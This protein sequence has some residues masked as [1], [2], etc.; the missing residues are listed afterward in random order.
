MRCTVFL[1]KASGNLEPVLLEFAANTTVADVNQALVQ[2]SLG[3]ESGSGLKLAVPAGQNCSEE[4]PA[5]LLGHGL[6]V[7]DPGSGNSYCVSG[8]SLVADHPWL[9]G[10]EISLPDSNKV[11]PGVRLIGGALLTVSE[12]ESYLLPKG[13][14]TVGFGR[15]DIDVARTLMPA[16]VTAAADCDAVP[17]I[18]AEIKVG[19]AVKIR[20]SNS[21]PVSDLRADLDEADSAKLSLF[22]VAGVRVAVE[23]LADFD[24]QQLVSTEFQDS[25]DL[26]P[27]AAAASLPVLELPRIAEVAKP[28]GMPVYAWVAPLVLAG[29]LWL[30]LQTPTVLIF[31]A[32]SPIMLVGSLLESRRRFKRQHRAVRE[33]FAADW[34]LF[35]STLDRGVETL[36]RRDELDLPALSKFLEAEP[37][38]LWRKTTECGPVACS[39]GLVEKKHPQLPKL[40]KQSGI[41]PE[42][43]SLIDETLVGR[44]TVCRQQTLKLKNETKLAV[45]GAECAR[46]S[47]IAELVLQLA[48]AYAPSRVGFQF[49]GCESL[50]EKYWFSALPHTAKWREAQLL[51]CFIGDA[52][53]VPK[54]EELAALSGQSLVI[55]C[56]AEKAS[57]AFGNSV[58]LGETINTLVLEEEDYQTRQFLSRSITDNTVK[59][60]VRSLSRLAWSENADTE[61]NPGQQKA[62][63]ALEL[64]EL[65]DFST[66]GVVSAV[67][68]R[69][70]NKK[71][72]L[73]LSVLCAERGVSGFDLAKVGPHALIAGTTGSG[74]SELLQSLLLGMA[75]RNSPEIVQFLLADFK[76]GATFGELQDLPHTIALVTDLANDGGE[77]L[78]GGLKR[79]IVRRETLLQ[80][81]RASDIE[82]F[83]SRSAETLPIWVVA[84]DECAALLQQHPELQVSLQDLAQRGRSLG[85]H[86]VLATQK[87]GG[88]IN[89]RTRANI[90]LLFAMR[91]ASEGDS[92][93][94]LGGAEA[95]RLTE[96]DK[97]VGF[98]RAAGGSM[99][100]FINLS[101][102]H[103]VL[104]GVSLAAALVRVMSRLSDTEFQRPEK[105]TWVQE[106]PLCLTR[107]KLQEI[108][109]AASGIPE[110]AIGIIELPEERQR[111]IMTFWEGLSGNCAVVA[112]C[113]AARA[114]ALQALLAA[115]QLERRDELRGAIIRGQSS[116]MKVPASNSRIAFAEADDAHQILRLL[117]WIK[118]QNQLCVVVIEDLN[119]VLENAGAA[120]ELIIEALQSLLSDPTNLVLVGMRSTHS[121]PVRLRDK[122]RHIFLLQSSTV[123][124]AL[125]HLLPPKLRGSVAN[126]PAQRAIY[127]PDVKQ[128]QLREPEGCGSWRSTPTPLWPLLK[129]T[130][131][132][133]DAL[134]FEALGAALVA[135]AVTGFPRHGLVHFGGAP[136]LQENFVTALIAHHC[137]K[138][139]H[140]FEVSSVEMPPESARL[141]IV[142]ENL[143]SAGILTSDWVRQ[144]REARRLERTIML[145][146]TTAG[147]L[148]YGLLPAGEEPDFRVWIP[149][150]ET[151]APPEW[152]SARIA[153]QIALIPGG[154]VVQAGRN[155]GAAGADDLVKAVVLTAAVVGERV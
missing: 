93:E 74:K 115:S 152:V 47:Y 44:K 139:E 130:T 38:K 120:F 34:Q 77:R 135:H 43:Q 128:I 55:V 2:Q 109:G 105:L 138:P 67:S 126:L 125:A 86:L 29:L 101:V 16:A 146:C 64:L 153:K 149:Q 107:A 11:P 99:A 103:L 119:R 58:W 59:Q 82:V 33:K 144:L 46:A 81:V 117:D 129:A 8:A 45:R 79:E 62:N 92:R 50:L 148:P 116:A 124:V 32:L 87:P 84:I 27:T 131:K 22:E 96:E 36:V 42:L 123:D 98:V 106:M 10:F 13:S 102:N 17:A 91:V 155:S 41:E 21:I 140:V 90:Q 19:T 6:V 78:L 48:V 145:I 147:R 150:S 49:I 65:T 51:I 28:K 127:L 30:V 112:E 143:L 118:Q 23:P 113:A 56:C 80:R 97:G 142:K 40:L 12:T 1:R 133:G 18:V 95:A 63:S 151:S 110:D 70:K 14:F 73:R 134:Q 75:V 104:N 89:D 66:A 85:I 53:F 3:S 35:L 7:K 132:L 68:A 9:S 71:P 4:F 57:S 39:L 111:K 31:T 141:V 15:G 72:D 24:T 25:S 154:A 60:V 69:W 137:L 54:C 76:G 100:G 136:K 52:A 108:A 114:T 20:L 121:I 37:V 83:N 88:V 5:A 122:L 61:T 26:P 94:L